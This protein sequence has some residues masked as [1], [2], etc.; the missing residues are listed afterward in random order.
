MR[1]KL[2]I[3]MSDRLLTVREAAERLALREGT[4]AHGCLVG[5]SPKVRLRR[6]VRISAEA[7]EALI[8]A[9][10]IPAGDGDR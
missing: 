6:A 7:V 3:T 8:S 9:G 2:G 5:A 4:T 10:T 1:A